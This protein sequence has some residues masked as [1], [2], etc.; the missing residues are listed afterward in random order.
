MLTLDGSLGEGGGQVLRTSL[1]LSAITGT[2][3]ALENIRANRSRPGLARQHLTCVRAAAE[4]CGATVEGAE[5]RST[6]IV[7]RPGAVKPGAYAFSIG[8]AGSAN[9]VLQTVL[10]PLMLA[11]APSLVSVDGGTHNDKSPPFH[12]LEKVFAPQLRRMG[13]GLTLELE[14]YG[15]FPA[16]GG[17]VTM[18]VEP[19]PLTPLSL[20]ERGHVT[21]LR[22]RAVVSALP[23]KV[24]RRELTELADHLGLGK[25][26][27]TVEEVEDP[28]GPG[29]VLM[30][31][32][33]C[34]HVTEL[35]TGFGAKG[36]P[37]EKLAKALAREVQR[38]LHA[39]VPVGPY[40]ADQLLLPLALAGG[41]H[42]KT[43]APD[44]HTPTNAAVI[45]RFL[46]VSIHIA[47]KRDGWHV[48]VDGTPTT[49]A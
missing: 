15:F 7:F 37:A 34:Q 25:R 47:E 6:R 46:D 38:W 27:G 35:F 31:E 19:G 28:V 17:R 8:T 45:Q 12:F 13:I 49:L 30:V 29:N 4:I 23:R 10:P 43:V 20:P 21:T 5:M 42:F 26:Y 9:L 1:A 14:R 24:G 44:P 2:P 32:V 39:N 18:Q 16:G 48:D 22:P 40:L 41:G 3:F 33:I 36:L 11:E